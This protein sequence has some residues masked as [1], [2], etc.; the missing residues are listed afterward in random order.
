MALRPEC[1]YTET[2]ISGCSQARMLIH[3]NTHLRMFSG[4]N[5]HTHKH[6]SQEVLRSL[7]NAD[8]IQFHCFTYARHFLSNCSALLGLE[9]QPA[10]GGLLH[11]NYNGHHVHVRACHV[12][13]D[14]DTVISRLQVDSHRCIKRLVCECVFCFGVYTL[15][16]FF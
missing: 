16:G 14:A 12:G 6:T 4:Q 2:R 5:A 8:M 10:R 11:L 1:S 13:I 9:Y 3:T 7:L 15:I